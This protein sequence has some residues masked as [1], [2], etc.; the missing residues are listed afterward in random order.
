MKPI[1]EKIFNII[2]DYFDHSES[3]LEG[4][5]YEGAKKLAKDIHNMIKY[6]T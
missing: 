1:Q 2:E 4:I 3:E 5:S 6:E